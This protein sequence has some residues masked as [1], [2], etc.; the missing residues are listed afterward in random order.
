MRPAHALID[1][2]ALRHNYQLARQLYGNKALAVIKANAYGHGAIRCAQTLAESADGFAVA[3]IEEALLLRHAGIQKPI[4]LLEGWFDPTELPLIQQYDLWVVIH[5]HGQLR[6]LDEAHI[7][8]PLQVWLKLDTG[9][10][11]VGFKPEEYGEIW[12]TLQA[13]DKV[14][15]LVKMTHF[16]R[17]DEPD[18]DTTMQQLLCFNETTAQLQGP[19]SLC[20]SAGALAWPQAQG[21]WLRPGIMLYGASP[22]AP[23]QKN[24]ARLKPVMQLNSRVIAVHNVSCG[25]SVGYGAQF[26]SRRPT[27]IGV[28]AMGY[29]DGYPRHAKSGTPVLVDNQRTE[30]IGR[31]SM[32]MLTVDLTDLPA[33]GLGSS[34]QLWGEGVLASEV[35]NWADTIP[36][37]LFC[38]LNRV[39]RH[40]LN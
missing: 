29:A 19:S 34:V 8:H 6:D 3:C 4:L 14:S 9:M 16:S 40:Y 15:S 17:A 18:C 5:H 12:R 21:D 25:E 2:G 20:N 23:G 11:R 13:T 28:V 27:R 1:L 39:P 26:I 36:Y 10:H 33:V 37:Q 31:V 35:A 22:F 32:D 30:L 7:E 24:A 38:N